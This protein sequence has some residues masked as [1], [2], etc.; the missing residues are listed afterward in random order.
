MRA[1][2]SPIWQFVGVVIALVIGVATIYLIL[3]DRHVKGL[4][5]DVLSNS[6]LVSVDTGVAREMQILYRG[7]Q[8]QTLSVI[9]LKFT[10][11]GTD[12]ITEADFSEPIRLTV[13]ANAAIGEAAVQETRP[14]SIRLTPTTIAP[15]QVELAKTLLNPGDQVVLKI[16]V[17]NNDT[18]LSISARIA[19]V[20]HLEVHSLL[21]Q[22]AK[23]GFSS[24]QIVALSAAAVVVLVILFALVWQTRTVMQWRK[25]RFGFD[26]ARY[27]YEQAQR[28]M[29][30]RP[31]DTTIDHVIGYL[32]SAFAWEIA[33]VERA[34]V[35][36]LFVQ[37]SEYVPFK[38]LISKY[39]S[40]TSG[41]G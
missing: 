35:D 7:K 28:I 2:K 31:K 30:L 22:N 25:E 21:E 34:K 1:L 13:S 24:D 23:T 16:L 40:P 26:P 14:A 38:E 5:V 27:Y 4:R 17:L 39:T 9:L 20:R 6:P 10:N 19:G 3:R 12:P 11:S 33:Y 36:P 41:N 37:L 15:N 18:T 8:V 29:I 32:R